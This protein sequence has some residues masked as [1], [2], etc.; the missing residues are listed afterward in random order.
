MFKEY[1]KKLRLTSDKIV[2]AI[3]AEGQS[4]IYYLEKSY[5]ENKLFKYLVLL[6]S[7][8][9][10]MN[11]FIDEVINLNY[12]HYINAINKIEKESKNFSNDELIKKILKI[13]EPL[14]E[15]IN[16]KVGDRIDELEDFQKAVILKFKIDLEVEKTEERVKLDNLEDD[17]NKIEK[18]LSPPLV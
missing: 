6:R 8:G 9:V 3:G 12:P 15:N 11:K 4:A 2:S 1:R 18:P 14:E 17:I 13:V 16:K 5:P 7:E 10:D